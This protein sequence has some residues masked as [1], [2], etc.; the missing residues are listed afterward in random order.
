MHE[1]NHEDLTAAEQ[2]EL[3]ALSRERQPS[4][5]LEE[6]TVRALRDR[7]LLRAGG[8][9]PNIPRAWRLAA[10]AAAV[11][12]FATGTAF[13]QWL[14]TRGA[15]EALVVA[16]REDALATA[17]H[18]QR[19]GTA[20]LDALAALAAAADSADAGELRQAREVALAV[21]RGAADEIA[22]IG[23]NEGAVVR[24]EGEA[25]Q[26]VRHVIWF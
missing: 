18:V 2:A 8:G 12:L 20:Y 4:R 16:G 23:G 5:L 22:R 14:G 9:S 21:F 11:A 13:G 25:A 6:R 7:G 26:E 15:A 1:S 19:A 17:L 3:A 24:Q 10:A